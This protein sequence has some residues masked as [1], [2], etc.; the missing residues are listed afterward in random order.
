MHFHYLA[1]EA[2]EALVL[3][4][5]WHDILAGVCGELIESHAMML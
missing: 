5:Q 1:M 4:P 3:R 2:A